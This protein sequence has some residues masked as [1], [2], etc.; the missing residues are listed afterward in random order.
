MSYGRIQRETLVDIANAI[1]ER[2]GTSTT[3]KP[4]QMA[5]AIRLIGVN[6]TLQDD[7]TIIISD[8]LFTSGQTYSI[9]YIDSNDNPISGFL[10]ITKFT[11]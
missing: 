4:N 11:T 8:S 6:M 10:D 9:K 1:R 7:G 2:S 3:Y 5:A